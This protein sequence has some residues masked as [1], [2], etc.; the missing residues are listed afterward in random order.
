M[1]QAAEYYLFWPYVQAESKTKQ[2]IFSSLMLCNPEG[3]CMLHGQ[4]IIWWL[5]SGCLVICMCTPYFTVMWYVVLLKL[6]GCTPLCE[7]VAYACGLLVDVRG[8]NP[9]MTVLQYFHFCRD[10]AVSCRWKSRIQICLV[11]SGS[12]L[13]AE[14]ADEVTA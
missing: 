10:V 7:S 12:E 8:S 6:T 9:C 4:V 13:T 11:C 3:C 1:R 14:V 2:L 5:S